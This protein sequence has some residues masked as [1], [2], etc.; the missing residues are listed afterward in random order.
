MYKFSFLLLPCLLFFGNLFAQV[1]STV[2]AR[3][4]QDT[5]VGHH[6][7]VRSDSAIRADSMARAI[8]RHRR[9]SLRRDSIRLDGLRK[10]TMAGHDPAIQATIVRKDSNVV[11]PAPPAPSPLG[12]QGPPAMAYWMRVLSIN[13]YF[14]FFGKWVA[15]PFEPHKPNSKDS[16]FYLL[17]G[18]LFYFALVRIFFE[19]YFSNLMTLFFRVSL[20]QQQIREQVLQTPLPS[21]LLNIL[22]IIT[23][24]LFACYL[25]H[26]SQWGAALN[27]WILY[28]DCIA[29]LAILYLG[30]FVILKFCGWVLNIS[31]AT[32]TYIF[33]VFL[34]NKMLGIFLLPFLILIT[35]SSP[36][37]REIFI[38]ISIV[39]IFALL[40]YRVVAAYRPVRNEI[41]LSP[42][43]FFSYICAFEIAP[44][45]LIYKVLLTYLGKV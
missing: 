34:V 16:F 2:P 26:F 15:Q 10:D 6:E 31:R 40:I 20:R 3:S 11:S 17:V 45:L 41:K 9:D 5:T 27:F 28:L 43:Y 8:R 35:F 38:T 18:I 1:D 7:T 37:I 36:E 13:P 4:V 39:M 29:G 21:L 32:D 33:V 22:F 44:L 14:N 12:E 42:F 25:L 19:K 23:G 30:K 24:G